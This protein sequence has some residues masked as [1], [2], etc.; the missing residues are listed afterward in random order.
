MKRTFLLAFAAGAL[1]TLFAARPAHAQTSGVRGVVADEQG[2]P[3]PEV[4]VEIQYQGEGP[5][6]VYHQKTNKK[7]GFV[8]IGMADGPYKIVLSKEG[9]QSQGI[10]KHL[11]LGEMFDLCANNPQPGEP[12][13]DLVLKKAQVVTTIQGAPGA[14][15]ARPPTDAAAA[16]AA[17]EEAA[18]LGA[19]YQA[20]VDA[21][22]GQQWDAAEAALKEVLAKVP[23]Q[24]TVLFNLGHVY[25]QKKNL[26]DAEAQFRRVAELEPTKPEGFISLAE[27]LVEE[28]KGPEAVEVLQKASPTFEQNV[29]FQT[30]LGATAMN[31]GR[32][33]E[34][35]AAFQK[36][37]ALDPT[38]AEIE[39]YLAS[40]SLNRND[41]A[42]SVAHLQKYLQSAPAGSPNLDTAKAL[43]TA[44]ERKQKK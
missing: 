11:G 28:G 31:T 23:D 40:L 12:C 44:L 37:Q 34:A 33:P 43:L 38:N 2:Q 6:R 42:V 19:T 5:K 9:Y 24:P 21:I 1:V 36:A 27:V 35:E 29:Q 25:R 3:L 14:T 18:K 39:F 15:G 8:R 10:E 13:K 20:A 26:P 22:K 7:G 4:N 41:V 17:S 32:E 30:A 16:K